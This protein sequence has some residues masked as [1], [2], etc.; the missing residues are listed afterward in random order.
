M[1]DQWLAAGIVLIALATLIVGLRICSQRFG[2]QPETVRKALHIG[3]G[4][5]A[6]TFPWI[7]TGPW[8]VFALAGVALGLLLA[9]RRVPALKTSFGSV[10]DSVDRVSAGELY[11]P[12]GIALSFWLTDGDPLLYG[13]PI[14]ILTLADAVAALIGIRYGTKR[15]ATLDG[16]KSYQGSLAFF[17]MAFACTFVPLMLFPRTG[18]PEAVLIAVI[19][20]V[21]TMLVEAVA[22]RGLDNLLLPV[23]GFLLLDS[24]LKLDVG[25]LLTNLAAIVL[26]CIITFLYRARSTL[27]DDALLTAVLVGY[28]I[29]A[30]GGFIWLYP[31]LVIFLRDKLISYSALGPDISRHNVQSILTICIPGL[32]WLVAAVVSG[33]G[34][35]FYPYVLSF[36]I[37]LSILELTREI[38]HYP[39]RSRLTAFL[40]SVG[41]GW[42]MF[43][44]FFFITHFGQP[45]LL[46]GLVGAGP[47]AL[48]VSLFMVVQPGID[49]CPRDLSRWLRQGA[50]AFA[51]SA[52]G[53]LL[54]WLTRSYHGHG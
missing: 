10:I 14:L 40:S 20:G 24:F 18:V 11:F 21:L 43:I 15:Y 45:W 48:G 13:V 51:A 38:Y 29:W 27:A 26:L 25:E 2:W 7:F 28:I 33:Q 39:S 22:W 17:G 34:G 12:V 54:L 47:I 9:L 36:A 35:L 19:I 30:L 53:L 23:I 8:P 32:I 41:V 3:M 5:V 1:H 49:H 37:H 44:P 31:P 16:T 46:L 6:L 42:L 50:S 4:T 52:A